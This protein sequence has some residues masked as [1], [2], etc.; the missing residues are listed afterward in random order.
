MS[1]LTVYNTRTRQKERFEPIEPGHARVYSCGPTVY[2]AQHLG[3]LRPY[4]FADLLRRALE[5]EGLR[6]THVINITD[7]GHLTSDADTG[8]D[9]MERAAARAGRKASEIAAFYTEKWLL[10]RRRL[11][12]VPP[13]VLPK[14]TEHIPEQIALAQILE[15]KGYTYR[16]ADGL[17]FDTRKFPRYAEFARLDLEGQEAGA[18]IGDVPEKHQPADFALWK[19]PVAGVERQQEWDSPWGRGFPG[20]HLECSAMSVKYLGKSFDIHTGGVDHIRVHHTN[21]IA[22]SECAFD[23]HPWVRYWLHNEFYEFGGEKMAKSTGNVLLLE[24]LLERGFEPLAFRYFFLQGHYRQQQS[25]TLEAMEAAATG[26]RRLLAHAAEVRGEKGEPD[27]GRIA[28][29]QARFRE[30]V[31]DD[32]N[33]PRALAVAWEVT[34]SPELS[35]ADKRS[36]LLEFDRWLGLGLATEEPRTASRESDPRIDALLARR[37][38][39]RATREFATADRIRKELEAEGILVEDTPE[40]PRW[41]R[42]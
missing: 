26:Y 39:A 29:L 3:N 16:I 15:A 21:E 32:L 22:Q 27:R 14:A 11:N 30:A 31:R 42:R 5:A 24:D 35:P 36:L 20:W 41:R 23:V 7:V 38:A 40:G 13:E 18:R 28:P 4:L 34:R 6:V 19:F 2:A 37:E 17:Y 12:C 10:D 8:E 1:T 9:K 33:A 25:F